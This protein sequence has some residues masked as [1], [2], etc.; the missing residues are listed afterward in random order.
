M[1]TVSPHA[2]TALNFSHIKRPQTTVKEEKTD[3]FELAL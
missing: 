3:K 1:S 2:A